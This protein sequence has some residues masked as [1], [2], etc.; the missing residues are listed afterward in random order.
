MGER[1]V[2]AEV[3]T[4]SNAAYHGD[5]S[6]V[7]KSMLTVFSDSPAEY[8]RRFVN[9]TDEQES[10]RSKFLTTGSLVDAML[11]DTGELKDFVEIPKWA[12]TT[13][14]QR[15]GKAWDKFT[16]MHR[17]VDFVTESDMELCRRLADRLREVAASYLSRPGYSQ[18]SIYWIDPDTGILCKCRPDKLIVDDKAILFD[19]KTT[20]S[21]E[22][23]EWVFRDFLYWLQESHYRA[24]V[25][26]LLGCEVEEFVFGVIETAD[27]HRYREYRIDDNTLAAANDRRRE[28]L[29]DLAKCKE[30]GNWGN[31]NVLRPKTIR[32]FL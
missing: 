21:L 3:R 26:H 5:R 27:P 23:F 24:G 12:L 25:R 20:V 18:C 6:A 8:C 7:S 4:Q 30:T 10:K 15:R 32:L 9:P 31:P 17:G 22:R 14:G 16:A 28:L 29:A 19:L 13:N 11:F 1:L 2:G